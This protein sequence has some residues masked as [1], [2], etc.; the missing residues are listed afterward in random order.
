VAANDAEEGAASAAILSLVTTTESREEEPS[1]SSSSSSM[2]AV[3]ITPFIN[4]AASITITVRRTLWRFV[5]YDGRPLPHVPKRSG[6]R[7]PRGGSASRP[8]GA[9]ALRLDFVVVGVAAVAAVGAGI[10]SIILFLGQVG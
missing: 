9:F 3:L 6:H 4:S 1:P 5:E 2:S 10:V 8:G 7:P